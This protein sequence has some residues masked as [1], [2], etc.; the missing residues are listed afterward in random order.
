MNP[1]NLSHQLRTHFESVMDNLRG[2]GIEQGPHRSLNIGGKTFPAQD[3][4]LEIHAN[5]DH[6]WSD[7]T[8]HFSAKL[9]SE[10]NPGTHILF[11]DTASPKD[12]FKALGEEPFFSD[13]EYPAYRPATP[14]D[15]SDPEMGSHLSNF[16][17]RKTFSNNEVKEF[18]TPNEEW[19]PDEM[20]VLLYRP[21]KDTAS[22]TYNTRTRQF[23]MHKS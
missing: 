7:S 23:K 1:E 2:Q 22:A 14:F 3:L 19:D 5:D 10:T 21:T 20:H 18:D 16:V 8:H 17:N 13:I 4:R 6:D 9:R 11:S 12:R 15:I